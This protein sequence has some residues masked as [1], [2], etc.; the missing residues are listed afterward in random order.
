MATATAT[1][2][3]RTYFWLAKA[4]VV[5]LS[6]LQVAFR[7]RITMGLRLVRIGRSTRPVRFLLLVVPPV[8][9]DGDD[10]PE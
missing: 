1:I 7:R 9:A 2:E 5:L 10:D 4:Q 3:V 8:L 6:L